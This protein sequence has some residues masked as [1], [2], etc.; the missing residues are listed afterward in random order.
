[1]STSKATTV[2]I[3]TK[4]LSTIGTLRLNFLVRMEGDDGFKEDLV[5]REEGDAPVD[6][7]QIQSI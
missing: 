1:M 2:T 5:K 7:T 3:S 6:C 4:S